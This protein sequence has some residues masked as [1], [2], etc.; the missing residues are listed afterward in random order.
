MDFTLETLSGINHLFR[1]MHE[2][3]PKIDS[4]KDYWFV[5][6]QKGLF[7][8]SFLS[9]GY[10][11]IGWNYITLDDLENLDED[12]IKR[13]IKEFDNSIEKPGSAYSQMM[14]FAYSLNIGDI[15][16]VPSESPN[17]FLIGE[18]TSRPYTETEDNI[19]SASNVCPYNKRIRV[20]WLGIIPNKDIDPQLYKLV[21]SGH[22]I[23]DAN[24]YKKF[25]NRGLYDAYIDH[26][27][28]SVT[29][30]VLEENNI[31]AFDYST[32]LH[33]VLQ[34]I[35]DIKSTGNYE[36]EKVILRT[37]VQSPGPLEFLG[38]PEL[39][40]PILTFVTLI[41]GGTTFHKLIKR[42]GATFEIDSKIGKFKAH[43]NSDGDEAIKKAQANEIN[44]RAIG[45]LIDKGLSPEFEG[46]TAQLNI[47]APETATKILQKELLE[48][49]EENE[50]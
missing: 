17:N 6:A 15:V 2:Q 29:F 21:Y 14:K 49:Q 16:V 28:M 12:S 25:I 36:D 35:N 30:R 43:L 31:D 9:G 11:A 39:L 3:L 41:L 38:P 18:I 48:S 47:K 13:R 45:L 23:T 34:M 37:N 27:C 40:I 32:F 1:R 19:E 42:N 44:A 7:Y 26:D 33:T 46:A 10:I 5:R 8:K 4:A 24:A 50:Q 22:T 20:H